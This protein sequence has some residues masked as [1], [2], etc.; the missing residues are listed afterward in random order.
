MST[1]DYLIDSAL[2]L[3]VL[4][5][6]KERPL[7]SKALIRPLVIVG[8]AVVNYLHGIPTAGNDL[9]LVGVLAMLGLLIGTA[10]GQTVL[11]RRGPDG[12]ILARARWL[13]GFFWVLGMGS[14]FAFLIWINNGGAATIGHFSTQHAI[15]SAEAWTVALLAMA[16]FE[17]CGRSLLLA[18]RRQRLQ[19]VPVPELA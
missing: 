1:T 14:R 10:S 4:L 8:I 3:L 11:M 6:I 7:T 5:Q 12:E 13:S 2:V 18:A 19:S 17:V 15:T 9:V 16:V